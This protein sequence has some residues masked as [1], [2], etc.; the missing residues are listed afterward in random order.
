MDGSEQQP[1]RCPLCQRPMD[2]PLGQFDPSA[3][4]QPQEA[5]GFVWEGVVTRLLQ[6]AEQRDVRAE[7]RD[8]AAI[9]RDYLSWVDRDVSIASGLAEEAACARGDRDQAARDRKASEEDR[10]YLAKLLAR[11]VESHY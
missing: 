6:E 10:V 11:T 8:R 3:G 7:L 5:K 4:S 9:E 1:A 2:D